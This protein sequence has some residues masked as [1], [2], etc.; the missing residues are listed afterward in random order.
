MALAEL[1]RAVPDFA[2]EH[3]RPVMFADAG[4]AER[5]LD[6]LRRASALQRV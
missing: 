2:I 3:A 1:M 6:G 5:T 4:A